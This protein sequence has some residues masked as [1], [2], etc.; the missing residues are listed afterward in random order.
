M[1]NM[2]QVLGDGL[3]SLKSLS[4]HYLARRT[5]GA[6][7]LR[8]ARTGLT[9]AAAFLAARWLGPAEYGRYAVALSVLSLLAMLGALG[10]PQLLTRS[11]AVYEQRDAWGLRTGLARRT[12][13]Y[14]GLL[15]IVL[16]PV[17]AI[18]TLGG[19]LPWP[20][21]RD[22]WLF[23]A[24]ACLV[25]PVVALRLMGAW[26]I[27]REQAMAGELADGVLRYLGVVLLIAGA[28]VLGIPADGFAALLLHGV[29]LC[30][31]AALVAIYLIRQERALPHPVPRFETPRWL[32]AA[33][34]MMWTAG[35]TVVLR[36]TD[37]V[38][39]GAMADTSAAGIYHVATRM[40]ELMALPLGAAE[41]VL[42]PVV[43]RLW[44]SRDRSQLQALVVKAARLLLVP[45]GLGFL[46]FAFA[47]DALLGIVGAGFA[48]GWLALTILVGANLARVAC[49]STAL[50]LN[51]SGFERDT[52]W[53][54]FFGT[55]ANVA[56]NF[57]LIPL[58]GLEGAAIATGGTMVMWNLLLARAVIRRLTINP[59]VFAKPA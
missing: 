56:L 53:A 3:A 18:A 43:A 17:A 58:Y 57:V 1:A 24:T 22:S 52:M 39:L 41:A 29:A 34:P 36:N 59:T 11:V 55:V 54:V 31:A 8:V 16:V 35:L 13:Q 49:G 21:P 32:L 25:V 2:T 47:G 28:I 40:A 19:F 44:A 23:F 38:M 5:A 42:A 26:L 37:I 15:A 9:F 33:L 50:L 7:G 4:G 27:G 14:V 48:A 46:V 12:W 10:L 45:A 20:P 6:G 30:A 51:M